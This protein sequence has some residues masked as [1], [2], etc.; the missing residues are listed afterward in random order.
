[1]DSTRTRPPIRR[2]V[3]FDVSQNIAALLQYIRK[4]EPSFLS[5]EFFLDAGA[6]NLD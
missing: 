6:T 2:P 4:E 5:Y 1:M 3:Q